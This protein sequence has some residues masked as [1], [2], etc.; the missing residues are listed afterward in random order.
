MLATASEG[1]RL[2]P[3]ASAYALVGDKDKAF[4]QL[5]K[6]YAEVDE[7]LINNIRFPAFDSIRSDPRY[8]DLM[9]RVGM[10]E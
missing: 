2:S 10:P 5:E 9:R 8:A 3:L 4:E 6:A 7:E 1:S